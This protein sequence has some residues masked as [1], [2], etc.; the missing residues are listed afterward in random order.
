MFNFEFCRNKKEIAQ[1]QQQ[2]KTISIGTIAPRM[3]L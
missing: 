3:G 2:P 1:I